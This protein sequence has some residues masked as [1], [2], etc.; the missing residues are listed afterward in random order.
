MR[1]YPLE[2]LINLHDAYTKHFKIDN[3]RMLLF[4]RRGEIFL[5]ES[6]C[7]HR[8]HPLEAATIDNGIIQ[9]ALHQ[10]RFSIDDGRLLYAS[11][12]PCRGLLIYDYIYQGNEVG[13]MLDDS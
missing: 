2:K 1:F 5:I 7:P 12:E 10:Y 9:C 13:V 4:Q 6:H 3:H 11:E 8:E